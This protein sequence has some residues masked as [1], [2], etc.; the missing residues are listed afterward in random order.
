M[1]AKIDMDCWQA[2][3][4]VHA[5][6]RMAYLYDKL[7]GK[8]D[9]F[10]ISL[11]LEPKELRNNLAS[12]IDNVFC[13]VTLY[14]VK[15]TTD[16]SSIEVQ[17]FLSKHLCDGAVEP[18][19]CSVDN[20]C[21]SMKGK[22]TPSVLLA[23]IS[24]D[25]MTADCDE[26]VRML[27]A[28]CL[29]ERSLR[30]MLFVIDEKVTSRSQMCNYVNSLLKN[31]PDVSYPDEC[32]GS[33]IFHR[34]DRMLLKVIS[35]YLEDHV[36][37]K[38]N[39]LHSLCTMPFLQKD[40]ENRSKEKVRVYLLDVFQS[41][42]EKLHDLAKQEIDRQLN[43]SNE[44]EKQ[45]NRFLGSILPQY[46]VLVTKQALQRYCSQASLEINYKHVSYFVHEY[47]SSN[48]SSMFS[49]IVTGTIMFSKGNVLQ[50]KH[51]GS[52]NA[53]ANQII[54]IVVDDRQNI[55]TAMSN[56][57][58]HATR[59][60]MRYFEFAKV[61]LQEIYELFNNI[62]CERFS[63]DV[64]IG[65]QISL[66]RIPGLKSFG[67]WKGDFEVS[68][69]EDKWKGKI[70][71]LMQELRDAIRGDQNA[72]NAGIAKENIHFRA[73]EKKLQFH[74]YTGESGKEC[75]GSVTLFGRRI[76]DKHLVCFTCKHVVP[77]KNVHVK[78]LDNLCD[79]TQE[80]GVHCNCVLSTGVCIHTHGVEDKNLLGDGFVDISCVSVKEP[81][82]FD[83]SI[84]GPT[85]GRNRVVSAFDR[86][87]YQ[88]RGGEVYKKGKDN[89]TA[90]GKYVDFQY[91]TPRED[92]EE[93]NENNGLWDCGHD[94]SVYIPFSDGPRKID[95][96]E[97][98]ENS[99]VS[100]G[101]RGHSGGL[102]SFVSW[103]GNADVVTPALVYVGRWPD[104][105]KTFMCYRLHEALECLTLNNRHAEFSL[106]Y[107]DNSYQDI[108][109]ETG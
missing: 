38:I 10:K 34:H 84:Q 102:V 107:D 50:R 98:T 42:H 4:K 79:H 24:G 41:T 32:K 105:D 3:L 21:S 109:P 14:V 18:D 61:H 106:N 78:L 94:H 86:N 90:Y 2:T 68:V 53:I 45:T 17:E 29:D 35:R 76:R 62:V 103:N 60:L 12:V 47:L 97:E 1:P 59:A 96:I 67:Y 83:I 39:Y 7:Y 9:T 81:Y 74:L 15:K 73:S 31:N 25:C 43:L 55:S 99:E 93:D 75:Y 46:G 23:L 70:P 65:A 13:P 66:C 44:C 56:E 22:K 80:N 64:Q 72:I 71:L 19:R 5:F 6:P 16:G 33:R 63:D 104:R 57:I 37:K 20:M 26:V 51:C 100:F 69:C 91:L 77:R 30:R 40:D 58:Q 49:G 92:E 52:P 11:P 88:R 108:H 48:S 85:P 28:Q 87:F 101:D 8:L 54:Q 36:G 82:P 89:R 27:K 95:L